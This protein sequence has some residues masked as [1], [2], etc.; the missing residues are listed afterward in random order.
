[1]AALSLFGLGVALVATLFAIAL[2]RAWKDLRLLYLLPLWAL[3][4]LM[5][6]AVTVWALTLEAR[7]ADTAMRTADRT[8]VVSRTLAGR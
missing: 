2:D 1:M 3:Y 6:S 7:G 5:M 8:G 4:S